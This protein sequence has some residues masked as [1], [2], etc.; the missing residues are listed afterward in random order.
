VLQTQSPSL[1]RRSQSSFQRRIIKHIIKVNVIQTHI[2]CNTL[3]HTATHC[4]T[5]QHTATHRNTLQHTATHRH[6]RGG[7]IRHSSAGTHHQSQR[8]SDL[9]Q[10]TPYQSWPPVQ[11]ALLY[12]PVISHEKYI[13]KYVSQNMYF[14]NVPLSKISR[15][16][17]NVFSQNTEILRGN[18]KK[19]KEEGKM[20]RDNYVHVPDL[21]WYRLLYFWKMKINLCTYRYICIYIFGK[22]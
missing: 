17:L 16:Y 11:L 20:R 10:N 19:K 15:M 14:C 1:E 13:Y 12:I 5:L 22:I 8:D 18:Y 9:T 4:N 7:A 6:S 3:Q 2:Y 21:H